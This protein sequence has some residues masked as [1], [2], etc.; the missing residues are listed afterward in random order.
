MVF[1]VYLNFDFQPKTNLP[2]IDF[3]LHGSLL[4]QKH[5]I[6]NIRRCLALQED[7]MW[8][9]LTTFSLTKLLPALGQ[10]SCSLFQDVFVILFWHLDSG[11]EEE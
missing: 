5:N 3:L 2:I 11:A 10:T 9:V 6:Q 1:R 7:E 8:S 4:K